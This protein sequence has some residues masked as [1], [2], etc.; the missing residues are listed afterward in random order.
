MTEMDEKADQ[1]EPTSINSRRRDLIP[2]W[3][4]VFIWIFLVFGCFVPVGIVLGFLGLS[5]DL[6]LYG[7]E[8]TQPF[9]V[10][11]IITDNAQYPSEV[12]FEPAS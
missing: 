10:T 8:T 6:S 2:L 11:G 1:P 7:L 12:G 9:T 5:F 4:K 3:I